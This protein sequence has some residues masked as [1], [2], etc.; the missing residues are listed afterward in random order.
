VT[1]SFFFVGLRD[2]WEHNVAAG[3]GWRPLA[4]AS[5][6]VRF[7][8]LAGAA[9]LALLLAYHL[10]LKALLLV[11]LAAGLPLAWRARAEPARLVTY[12]LLLAGLCIA[13]GVELVYIR[14]YLDQSIYERMNTVFKFYFEVWLCLALGCALAL[15]FL[16]PRVLMGLDALLPPVPWWGMG[17]GRLSTLADVGTR[18]AAVRP[19]AVSLRAMVRG[20]WL[21]LLVFLLAGSSIFLVLGT[22]ARVFEHLSWAQYQPPPGGIQPALPSLDGMAYMRGWYPSDYAAINWM[23]LHIAGTPTIVEATNGSY[24]WYGRV[25]IYTGLPTVL[26]WGDHEAEQRNAAE[27]YAR[28]ADVVAFYGTDDPAAALEFLHRYNVT[29]VYVGMLEQSCYTTGGQNNGCVSMT[30][31]ALTKFATLEDEGALRTVYNADH[32]TIYRVVE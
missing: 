26:G 7:S 18:Q 12:V 32:T 23:N 13:L 8:V 21:T 19:G 4:S 1:A 16:L 17:V 24:L 6:Q 20:A 9:A 25:S 5:A 3:V 28:Q 31:G 10:S 22:Q 30:G 29:Y 14:D 11:L 27:V 2:W 15:T